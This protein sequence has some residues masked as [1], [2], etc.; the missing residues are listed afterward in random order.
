[1]LLE[2]EV[3]LIIKNTRGYL[4][5]DVGANIGTHSIIARRSFDIV[6]AIEPHPSSMKKF[7]TKIVEK[8][9]RN[10]YTM[11]VAISNYFSRG[12]LNL[13]T[14]SGS[15]RLNSLST[16]TS[17]YI[18]VPVVT[19]AS[20]LEDGADLIKVD[21]EGSEFKVVTGARPII[22][23]IKAW[24]IEVHDMDRR[25]ELKNIMECFGYETR[26]LDHGHLYAYRS[27]N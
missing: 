7:R 25:R 10:I 14:T 16:D 27:N 8:K 5:V 20:L 19:L 17:K 24:I 12:R 2:N 4:F 23:K 11:C 3:K 15:H 13:S 22:H 26:W 6:I 21:V 18:T 1:M 9:I